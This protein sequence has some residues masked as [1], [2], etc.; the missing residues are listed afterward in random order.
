MWI[1][2][3]L[4][5]L[6]GVIIYKSAL[7]EYNNVHVYEEVMEWVSMQEDPMD[8]YSAYLDDMYINYDQLKFT[9]SLYNEIILLEQV[10]GY[11][12]NIRDYNLTI[13]KL[14]E[15]IDNRSQFSF[16]SQTNNSDK[17]AKETKK[18]YMEL[19]DTKPVGGNYFAIE[20]FMTAGITDGTLLLI[21]IAAC[22]FLLIEERERGMY[23]LVKTTKRGRTHY[24][25]RKMGALICITIIGGVL[26]YLFS[27]GLHVTI[28]GCDSLLVPIQSVPGYLLSPYKI[29]IAEGL[30]QFALLKAA[31]F[32]TITTFVMFTCLLP[33][34]ASIIYLLNALV[35]GISAAMNLGIPRSSKYVI[36]KYTNFF[37]VLNV[38]NYINSLD[39]FPFANRDIPLLGYSL[40]IMLVFFIFLAFLGAL[41]YLFYKKTK[42]IRIDKK[43]K[44]TLFGMK[45]LANEMVR[46]FIFQGGAIL[47]VTYMLSAIY[48]HDF[49]EV[50]S[51]TN[52]YL[53]TLVIMLNDMEKEQAKSW[54]DN[55][56]IELDEFE[57]EAIRLDNLF[58]EGKI[59]Q[60][61][62][63]QGIEIIR[64]QLNIK[65]VIERLQEQNQYIDKVWDEREIVCDYYYDP[66]YEDVFG[67]SGRA[68]RYINGIIIALFTICL[69][70][71]V[72]A[73]DNQ[74]SMDRLLL[75]TKK[76]TNQLVKSRI[77]I[78]LLSGGFLLIA[79]KTIRF[80]SLGS[81]HGISGLSSPIQSLPW[82]EKFP[83]VITVGGLFV[84]QFIVET[85]LILIVCLFLIAL[86]MRGEEVIQSLLYGL[87]FCLCPVVLGLL[88]FQPAT[89]YWLTPF[90]VSD[91]IFM[92]GNLATYINVLVVILGIFLIYILSSNKWRGRHGIKY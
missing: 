15:N 16:L 35:I 78:L 45:V 46:F 43:K 85:I 92:D 79:M 61:A 82:F 63:E 73:Y 25:L 1:V 68:E 86:S 87:I 67:E 11:L 14:I 69:I 51:D 39:Y 13:E 12:D 70:I 65:P 33:V 89:R 48:M 84:F 10:M 6:N 5:F 34:K 27:F 59:S 7:D 53:K 42:T 37:S 17:S 4:F 57:M 75:V 64:E 32:T 88:S 52:K 91:T 71:P 44:I 21:I 50:K 66:L 54:I 29:N 22:S 55:K 31:A 90:F 3:L 72:F 24:Y 23:Q 20:K 9:D 36:L 49:E 30:I 26:L 76:G 47:L 2:I 83:L 56:L 62:H 58:E 60:S 19:S 41:A 77:L 40:I 38:K 28:Y 18:A 74:Y 81:K 80:I 8:A